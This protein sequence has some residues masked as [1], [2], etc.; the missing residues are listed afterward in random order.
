MLGSRS[1]IHE[2]WKATTN[3]IST[4]VLDEEELPSGS[5]DFADDRWE[6]FNLTEDFSEAVDRA[7]EEPA[8]LQQ[9]TDLWRSEAERNQVLPVSDGMLDRLT[10][11]IPPTWPA[12]SS[13]TF[14]P[15]SGPV[16]D[17]SVPLLWGGFVLTAD[18]DAIGPETE[19]VVVALGDWVGGVRPLRRG[20]RRQ[21][22]VLACRADAL[23]LEHASRTA[24]RSAHPSGCPTP[25]VT[26]GPRGSWSS[27]LTTSS[28]T[29]HRWQAHCPSRSNTAGRACGSAT[30]AAFPSPGATRRPGGS[31]GVVHF[32]SIEA[33]G[34]PVPRLDDEVRAALHGD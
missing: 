3:H 32:V 29:P 16:H 5:R 19:G 9:L 26:V 4:G 31:S 20:R 7:D 2:G 13:R 17:E 6:L 11:L 25:S 22:H 1:I 34:A 23:H 8:L 28:S 12:G 33:P 14:L 10:G 30:T 24:A 18:V 15:E 27:R 21:L